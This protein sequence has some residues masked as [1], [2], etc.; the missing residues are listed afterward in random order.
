MNNPM[1]NTPLMFL[2]KIGVGGIFNKKE[3]FSVDTYRWYYG[4]NLFWWKIEG[5]EPLNG[6]NVYRPSDPNS[7]GFCL[8]VG[9]FKWRVRYSKR[10]KKWFL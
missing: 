3:R 10:T 1:G 8:K 7:A 6:I 9:K 5:C 2:N 4:W